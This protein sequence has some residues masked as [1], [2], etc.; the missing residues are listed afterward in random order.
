MCPLSLHLGLPW[1]SAHPNPASPHHSHQTAPRTLSRRVQMR[2]ETKRQ[3]L[4]ET[5][6]DKAHFAAVE[7]LLSKEGI[8]LATTLPETSL[9]QR[10]GVQL[11]GPERS[12]LPVSPLQGSPLSPLGPP[13]PRSLLQLFSASF[14]RQHLQRQW[15]DR[16]VRKRLSWVSGPRSKA[17]WARGCCPCRRRRRRRG[18]DAVAMDYGTPQLPLLNNSC[19]ATASFRGQPGEAG[20]EVASWLLSKDPPPALRK[21]KKDRRP[22]P[23]SRLSPAGC[24]HLRA[25]ASPLPRRDAARPRHPARS[26]PSRPG[27]PFLPPPAGFSS[28]QPCAPPRGCASDAEARR[29]Q[30]RPS[31][32]PV[33]DGARRPASAQEPGPPACPPARPV[34]AQAAEPKPTGSRQPVPATSMLS[35]RLGSCPPELKKIEMKGSLQTAL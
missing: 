22:R 35:L 34:R 2:P 13:A 29:P 10:T 14:S 12:H 25:L 32:P 1:G 8:Q 6:G 5:E 30:P 23:R 28:P 4:G 33:G 18:A 24:A 7:S 27:E 3:R 15:E 20:A 31:P 11:P 9:P 16:G 26:A 21:G 19:P 17:A